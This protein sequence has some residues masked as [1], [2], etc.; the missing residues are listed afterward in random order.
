MKE[1]TEKAQHQ[2]RGRASGRLVTLRGNP[3]FSGAGPGGWPGRPRGEPRP[4]LLPARFWLLPA[5][6]A[7]CP[8]LGHHST[9]T[10]RPLQALPQPLPQTHESHHGPLSEDRV[11]LPSPT[12][13]PATR[14]HPT[15]PGVCSGRCQ[16][17][18]VSSWGGRA[19]NRR[20]SI[21]LG[22]YVCG[23]GEIKVP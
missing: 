17:A 2:A 12:P 21:A 3:I 7:L 20:L 8:G 23:W 22:V 1:T 5:G 10:P 16:R 11:P 19:S 13:C 14:T 6:R 18:D 9:C 4:W 15:P